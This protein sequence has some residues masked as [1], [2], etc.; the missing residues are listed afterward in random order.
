MTLFFSL[1]IFNLGFFAGTWWASRVVQRKQR[2]AS[3]PGRPFPRVTPRV[4]V[5]IDPLASQN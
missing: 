4:P 5:A 3:R 1:L 2:G